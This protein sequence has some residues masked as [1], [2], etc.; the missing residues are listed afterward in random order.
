MDKV[1]YLGKCLCINANG[2]KLLIVGDLH[3]GYEE[4]LNEGGVFV[5]REMFKEMISYFDRVFE[6]VGKVEYVILLGDVKHDFGRIL[7]QEQNDLLMLFGYLEGKLNKGGE[8]VIVKGNHD[9]IVEPIANSA[10]VRVSDYFT[11][12][13]YCFIHGDREL[14]GILDDGIRFWI[15]GHGHPAI[16]LSDGIKVEKYKCFLIGQYKGKEIIIVPSFLEYNEGSD[17]RENDLGMAWDFNYNR[18]NVKIVNSES[19]EVLDFGKL[20]KLKL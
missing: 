13:E 2:K 8:I 12:G 1:E 16:R 9:K 10:G 3:L 14:V 15:M 11:I 19:L 6:R 20:G 18:F 7:R 17:P 4:V 5:T